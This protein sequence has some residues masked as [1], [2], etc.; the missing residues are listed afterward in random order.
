MK[1]KYCPICG[2]Y[3]L[4]FIEVCES[5]VDVV[6]TSWACDCSDVIVYIYEFIKEA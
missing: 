3:T 2:N 5:D 6:K 1:N 4:E